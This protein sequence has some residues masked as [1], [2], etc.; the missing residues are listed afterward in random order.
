MFIDK[1]EYF[2]L[3]VLLVIHMV[4]LVHDE[5]G[6]QKCSIWR[7]YYPCMLCVFV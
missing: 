6:Y 7:Y 4:F 3:C 5:R 2:V 1:E